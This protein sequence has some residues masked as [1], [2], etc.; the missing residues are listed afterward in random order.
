MVD[1]QAGPVYAICLNAKNSVSW[2]PAVPS[3]L[4]QMIT[5]VLKDALELPNTCLPEFSVITCHQVAKCHPQLMVGYTQWQGH[6]QPL[7]VHCATLVAPSGFSRFP[8]PPS[9]LHGIL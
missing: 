9:R 2:D 3:I 5:Q 1:W 8:L 7:L 4:G 6:L